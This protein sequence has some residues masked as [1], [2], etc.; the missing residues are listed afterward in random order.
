MAVP[1]VMND[2]ALQSSG[3][4]SVMI[5]SMPLGHM[6]NALPHPSNHALPHPSNHAVVLLL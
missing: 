3:S 6:D 2:L 1:Y 5:A 4:V